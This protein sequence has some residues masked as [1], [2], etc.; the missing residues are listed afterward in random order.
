METNIGG[1]LLEK[2]GK[3]MAALAVPFTVGDG[4]VEEKSWRGNSGEEEEGRYLERTVSEE[5]C[6]LMMEALRRELEEIKVSE[7]QTHGTRR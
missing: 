2:L 5:Q 4:S 1:R 7:P 6:D 3:T